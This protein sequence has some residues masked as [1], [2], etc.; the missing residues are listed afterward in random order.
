MTSTRFRGA[1]SIPAHCCCSVEHDGVFWS[2]RSIL[3]HSGQSGAFWSVLKHSGAF[4]PSRQPRISECSIMTQNA[5]QSTK[6]LH[7]NAPQTQQLHNA[8]EHS[9]MLKNAQECSRMLPNAPESSHN[10]PP[11][12]SRMVQD[13]PKGS[14]S[15]QKPLIDK[16]E[17]PSLSKKQARMN[18]GK[19]TRKLRNQTE[20]GCR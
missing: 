3:E 10:A 12:R 11:E 14:R 18:H 8:P 19:S 5:P 1:R 4:E 15:L 13:A 2:I 17:E 20:A 6:M 9:R 16:P 7:N